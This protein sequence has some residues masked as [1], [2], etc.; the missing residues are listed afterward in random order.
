M[1]HVVLLCLCS[2]GINLYSAAATWAEEKESTDPLD[3]CNPHSIRRIPRSKI[4][5]KK[6]IWR[7]I[8]LTDRQN[9]PFFTKGKEI[10]K[11]IFEGVE[12]GVLTPYKDEAFTQAMSVEEFLEQRKLPEEGHLSAEEKALGFNDDDHD[13]WGGDAK[14]ATAHKAD[15][16][17]FLPNE[18]SVLEL[19]I[20]RI[21][22]KGE[23]TRDIQSIKIIIPESKFETGLRRTVGIFKYKDLFD[24]FNSLGDEALWFNEDN[25]ARHLNFTEAFE[26]QLFDSRIVKIENSEDAT[27]EDVHKEKHLEVAKHLE[28][29]FVEQEC[30]FWQP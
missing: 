26:A 1:R 11:I 4:S 16:E 18:A 24:Y 3:Q 19:M 13:D 12:K 22:V 17:Y 10:T 20:D 8:S 2:L 7:E 15:D 27:L 30:S 28:T 29:K 23:L 5:H 9:K 25:S 6:R 14:K 21:F